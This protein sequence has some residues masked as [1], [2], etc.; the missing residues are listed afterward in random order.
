MVGTHIT[1]G[2]VNWNKQ[3]GKIYGS[4]D[5]NQTCVPYGPAVLLLIINPTEIS[6]Y[7]NKN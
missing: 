3:F 7:I 2:H 5:Y 6:L 1:S 4:T